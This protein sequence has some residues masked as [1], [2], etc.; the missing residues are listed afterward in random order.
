[1]GERAFVEWLYRSWALRQ[2]KSCSACIRWHSVHCLRLIE[3]L[4]KLWDCLLT[5]L[6]RLSFSRSSITLFSSFSVGVLGGIALEMGYTIAIS[7][8]IK[9]AL[10]NGFSSP[11]CPAAG[12][13]PS[14]VVIFVIRRDIRDCSSVDD[15]LRILLPGVGRRT[16]L[17]DSG[18]EK[19][20][21][22]VTAGRREDNR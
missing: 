5:T 10:F 2:W 9:W 1:M 14:P 15:F 13:E 18:P 19:D 8:R 16:A 6:Y 22:R 21:L 17:D 3:R 11:V 7:G 20:L 12:E 4:T